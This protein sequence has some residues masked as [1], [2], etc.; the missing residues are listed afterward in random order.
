MFKKICALLIGLCTVNA[1]HAAVDADAA[2]TAAPVIAA[3][4]M[5]PQHPW[6]PMVTISGGYAFMQTTNQSEDFNAFEVGQ[7]NLHESSGTHSQGMAG[8]F[9]GVEVLLKPQWALQVGLG[10]YMPSALTIKGNET[11]G[12]L[13]CADTFDAYQYQYTVSTHQLLLESKLLYAFTTTYHPFVSLGVGATVNKARSY[14]INNPA[15]LTFSPQFVNNV[16]T[17]LSYRVGVGMDYELATDFRIGVGYYF[18]DFGRTQLAHGRVDTFPV[19]TT[20]EQPNLFTNE[21]VGEVTL[22]L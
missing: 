14:M 4:A 16:T 3:P 12:V 7:F 17:Q 20:L 13:G 18:S 6:H 1:V 21:L 11:Q 15:F 5:A 2:A 22:I 8:G 10:L 9:A 19:S